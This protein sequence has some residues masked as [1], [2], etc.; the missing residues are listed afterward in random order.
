MST[1]G[2]ELVDAEESLAILE[3]TERFLLEEVGGSG[4]LTLANIGQWAENLA[5]TREMIANQRIAV[6]RLRRGMGC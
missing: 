2:R 4:E 5:R 3:E 6:E 1:S